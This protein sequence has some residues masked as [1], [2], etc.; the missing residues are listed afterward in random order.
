MK[1]LAA[2][3]S[4]IA[5]LGLGGVLAAGQLSNGPEET[6]TSSSD[7]A[8]NAQEVPTN[9]TVDTGENAPW[10]HFSI[11]KIQEYQ[12][13]GEIVY[14]YSDA[15]EIEN[16]I[17]EEYGEVPMQYIDLFIKEVSQ[18]VDNENYF[19]KLEEAK[20]AIANENYDAVPTLIEE[21]KTLRES[22]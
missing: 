7:E 4:A 16:L 3:I 21:A 18:Y 20:E 11:E 10:Q 12:N 15:E 22:E 19:S 5:V 9:R 13:E 1:K 14:L 8:N 6:K 2:T 17:V